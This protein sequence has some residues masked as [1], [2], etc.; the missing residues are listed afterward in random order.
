MQVTVFPGCCGASVIH[1]LDGVA[2]RQAESNY[3]LAGKGL[4]VAITAS[5]QTK[6][7][8]TLKAAGYRAKATFNNPEGDHKLT[9]WVKVLSKARQAP[10]RSSRLD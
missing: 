6:A 5:H 3:Q 10:R 4:V 2:K 7:A 1:D 9:L 8:R